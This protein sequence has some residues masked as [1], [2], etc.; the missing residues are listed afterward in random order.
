M[1]LESMYK[2]NNI[3]RNNYS[4]NSGNNSNNKHD[5]NSC[6]SIVV[7]RDLRLVPAEIALN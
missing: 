4:I 3:N 2:N 7:Y 5:I 1:F 6:S